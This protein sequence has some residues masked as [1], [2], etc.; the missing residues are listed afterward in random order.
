MTDVTTE[1]MIGAMTDVETT[2]GV[3]IPATDETASLRLLPEIPPKRQSRPLQSKMKSS[4]QR[5]RSLKHGKKREKPR[6]LWMRP[7]SKLWHLLESLLVSM[8]FFS[9]EYCDFIT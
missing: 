3:H 4:K 7:R 1:E 2:G 6:K 8:S 5:G 9:A